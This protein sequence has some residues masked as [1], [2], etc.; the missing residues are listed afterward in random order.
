MFFGKQLFTLA[1][2]LVVA[3]SRTI[4]DDEDRNLRGWHLDKDRLLKK[5][6]KGSDDGT[7]ADNFIPGGPVCPNSTTCYP[8]WG[9]WH[10][11]LIDG[12]PVCL[13]GRHG[14][15]TRCAAVSDVE[16]MDSDNYKCGPC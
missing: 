12:I 4:A 1:L 7:E 2:I 6:S 16:L 9:W 15:L 13:I 14:S 10:H 3:A 5:N 8:V 11:G